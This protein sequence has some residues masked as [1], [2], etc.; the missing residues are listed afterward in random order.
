MT[1]KWTV[2]GTLARG[3]HWPGALLEISLIF[4]TIAVRQIKLYIII[5]DWGRWYTVYSQVR[6]LAIHIHVKMFQND[7]SD[8]SPVV[9][10]DKFKCNRG[11]LSSVSY[12][13]NSSHLV[14]QI[15]VVEFF[16]ESSWEGAIL[17]ENHTLKILPHY[18]TVTK[19][20]AI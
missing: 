16:S 5:F 15:F 11:L 17:W 3:H 18:Q 12:V 20:L 9:C 8:N 2:N 10:I 14:D 6:F 13:K 7:V 1:R 4:Y 19:I